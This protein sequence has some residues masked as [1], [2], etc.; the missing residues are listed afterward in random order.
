MSRLHR[1]FLPAASPGEEIALCEGEARHVALVLRLEPGTPVVGFDGRGTLYDA[2]LVRVEPRS[3][4]VRVERVTAAPPPPEPELTLALAM[5][6][7]EPFEWAIQKATELGCHRLQPLLG[8]FCAP[9]ARRQKPDR[10]L[11]RWRRISLESLKQC[12]RSETME[13]LSPRVSQEYF[14]GGHSGERRLLHPDRA[15][16]L[17]EH[18][19]ALA[20]RP[21]RVAVAVGPEGGWSPTEL[22]LAGQAGFALFSLGPLVL[23]SETAAAAALT[24]LA[25]RFHWGARIT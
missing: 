20:E 6:R 5:V 8:D 23:R 2:V 3:T 17:P 10:R 21:E 9:R 1:V 24:L 11:D 22:A 7:D 25:A 12:R 16:A 19:A 4:V 14:A 18:L 15:P 13:I